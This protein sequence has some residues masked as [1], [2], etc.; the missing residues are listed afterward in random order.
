MKEREKE[1]EGNKEMR[2]NMEMG[3]R[4]KRKE[5]PEAEGDEE[6][7]GWGAEVREEDE[8]RF[9]EQEEKWIQDE[10][11]KMREGKKAY[12]KEYHRRKKEALQ[13]PI[14]LDI[15]CGKGEY[16]KVTQVSGLKLRK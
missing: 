2:E 9:K 12:M 6:E 15:Q 16:A 11:G 14:E 8:K 1:K 4:R 10:M 5:V 7:M 3:M 13:Q